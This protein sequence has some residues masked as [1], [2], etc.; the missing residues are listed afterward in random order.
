MNTWFLVAGILCLILTPIHA[1]GG[2]YVFRR[3]AD[4]TFPKI[5]NGDG[6]I[7]KQEVRFSWH[8]V[9]V[10]FIVSGIALIV[11]ALD[12]TRIGTSQVAFLIACYF[13]GYAI[14]IAL[15]PIIALRTPKTL[16]ISPQ[17][18]AC[19]AVALLIFGGIN[20]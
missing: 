11:L 5:P 12:S 15:L 10:D 6:K 16:L 3:M 17:W 1:W 9:S 8:G 13:V 2:E 18:I 7:A 14:V 20:A 4:E 19:L